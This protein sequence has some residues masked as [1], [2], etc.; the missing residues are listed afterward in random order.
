MLPKWQRSLQCD[1]TMYKPYM[2]IKHAV[3]H[4]H[5]HGHVHLHI[6]SCHSTHVITRTH[7]HNSRTHDPNLGMAY[8]YMHT[9][10]AWLLPDQQGEFQSPA[11]G[12]GDTQSNTHTH[13]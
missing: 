7:M 5:I 8:V 3:I 4:I 1:V 11:D 6:R 12:G 9:H 2:N 13:K 10:I